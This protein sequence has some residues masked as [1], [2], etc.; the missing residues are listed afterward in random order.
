M[1]TDS[2]LQSRRAPNFLERTIATFAPERAVRRAHA[3]EVMHHF[4]YDGARPSRLRNGTGV[5]GKDGGSAETLRLSRDRV[6]LMREARDME[7]NFGLIAGILDRI[8]TYVTHRLQYQART[9]DPDI[10]TQYEAYFHDWCGV[11]DVTGRHRFRTLLEL[12]LRGMIRDGDFG[13]NLVKSGGSLRLQSI[14]AD[15]LGS[16]KETGRSAD[17]N[18]LNGVLINDLGQPT[19]Y[20]IFK[21]HPKLDRYTFEAD[22]PAEQFIH[23]FRPTRVDQY[24]GVSALASALPHA[25][26]LYE[27]Y[28]LA[29]QRAKFAS[30]WSGFIRS[31]DPVGGGAGQWDTNTD[32][33]ATKP[34][35]LT[36]AAG[37]VA[38][39]RE[40]EDIVFPPAM[41]EPS[42]AFMALAE[43]LIR[44]IAA[45]VDL[46]YGFV[47]DMS[48]LGGVSSRIVTRQAQRKIEHWQTLLEDQVCNRVRDQV[49]ANGIA[50]GD[51]P[52]HKAWRTGVWG[53]G[54]HITADVGHETSA[55]IS[56]LQYGLNTMTSALAERGEDFEEVMQARAREV[57]RLQTIAA[58]QNVPIELILD[59][60]PNAT[61]LLAAMNTPAEKEA[62]PLPGLIGK[63]GERGVKPLLDVLEQVGSGV[64]DR[65]SGIQTL[66][67]LYGLTLEQAQKIVPE[68]SEP[69][70]GKAASKDEAEK[71]DE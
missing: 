6:N 15:R 68:A 38:R 59:S 26:D 30:M 44:E 58:E 4:G 29:K 23:L 48:A 34:N 46:P 22:L 11:A 40:D 52:A 63:Y 64:I 36:A 9:G 21:R 14:E 47:Y 45:G 69:P 66:V 67:D 56:E 33:A 42:G 5:S 13:F 50:R 55:R 51:I 25:R 12:A 62:K 41:S 1:E 61:A 39:L 10:N 18:Y 19:H 8:A 27:L 57:T 53:W 7:R 60:K 2:E 17:A 43:T 71:D 70:G 20:R 37:K 16:A 24:R 65:E 31:R 35:N 28:G 49:L 3:R 32:G 54:A